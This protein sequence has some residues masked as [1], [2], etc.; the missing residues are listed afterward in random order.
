MVGT[1]D[2]V[3]I[4]EVFLSQS[5]RYRQVSLYLTHL[6]DLGAYA[7]QSSKPDYSHSCSK[8]S[9]PFFSLRYFF[10]LLVHSSEP[11]PCLHNI[12]LLKSAVQ[13]PK[14]LAFLYNHSCLVNY[15]LK[16]SKYNC[17]QGMT[18]SES[19]VLR[20]VWVMP[21]SVLWFS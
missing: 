18:A 19:R 2:R 6:R 15:N 9:L 17:L 20:N 5:A 13:M 1:A 7:G 16:V 11:A 8:L 10:F 3:L 14:H 21:K 12:P 4:R